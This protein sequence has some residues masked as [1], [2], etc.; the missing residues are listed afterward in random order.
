[1]KIAINP[2]GSAQVDS[3]DEGRL[4]ADGT[5]AGEVW[6]V[7][8][9]QL[10]KHLRGMPTPR[11]VPTVAD[12]PWSNLSAGDKTAARDAAAQFTEQ[13]AQDARNL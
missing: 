3:L 1:M 6:N 13:A 8:A 10:G 5:Q 4:N 7:N 12:H 2:D 9:E 11:K